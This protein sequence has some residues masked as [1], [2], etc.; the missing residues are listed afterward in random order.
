MLVDDCTRT[1]S[2]VTGEVSPPPV[3]SE[4]ASPA[5]DGDVDMFA[6]P[7][8]P[9]AAAEPLEKI[10]TLVEEEEMDMDLDSDD[11]PSPPPQ[12]TPVPEKSTPISEAP[13]A[14]HISSAVPPAPDAALPEPL[15]AEEPTLSAPLTVS[16][17]DVPPVA[18]PAASKIPA[19]VSEPTPPVQ[20]LTSAPITALE[21][22]P[23]EEPSSE[24]GQSLAP[25]AAESLPSPVPAISAREP[26]PAQT[27][28]ELP[29]PPEPE[30]VY[31]TTPGIW[32]IRAGTKMSTTLEFELVIDEATYGAARRWAARWDTFADGPAEEFISVR[33]LGLSLAQV[34][35]LDTEV[36]SGTRSS[37][38]ADIAASMAALTVTWPAPGS[39]MVTNGKQS[40]YGDVFKP[41]T[42][43]DVS[44]LVQPG[45]N[46]LRVFL[47]GASH[48]DK[49]Y[50]LHA[51]PPSP[52]EVR[53][54]VEMWKAQRALM[55]SAERGKSSFGMSPPQS[56]AGE[57]MVMQATA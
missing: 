28:D 37:A 15:A 49:V 6:P 24:L 25:A 8:V 14:P 46:N 29:S 7:E 21:P 53:A 36:H 32:G 20:T 13:P 2:G 44:S 11:E 19:I 40:L 55:T 16:P 22:A 50:A 41:G 4:L 35:E 31:A 5:K 47:I 52:E 17:D 45:I 54:V 26:A 27:A 9:P 42:P 23:T 10:K 39:L 34:Q 12:P 48:V 38:P 56:V 3:F 30:F 43:F 18:P 51:A 57:P 33:L 1:Q